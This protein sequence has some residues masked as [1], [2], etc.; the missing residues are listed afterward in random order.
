MDPI[1][2]VSILKK[3]PTLRD[4]SHIVLQPIGA[5]RCLLPLFLF[6]IIVCPFHRSIDFTLLYHHFPTSFSLPTSMLH[7]DDDPS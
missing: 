1:I 6:S 2:S 3:D 5:L 7:L 4:L